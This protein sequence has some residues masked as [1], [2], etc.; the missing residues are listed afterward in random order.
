MDAL[1]VLGA[2]PQ[3]G[4]AIAV[5]L[6]G[7]EDHG[8]MTDSIQG[9]QLAVRADSRDS[10]DTPRLSEAAFDRL[11][12]LTSTDW[13]GV[14]IVHVYRNSSAYLGVDDNKRHTI[15]DSYYV[16]L[17]RVGRHRTDT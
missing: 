14:P 5:N 4:N 11:H 15:T 12:G 9:I 6:Y 2:L 1:L 13:H 10:R 17:T 7:V 8:T 16:Q 3:D